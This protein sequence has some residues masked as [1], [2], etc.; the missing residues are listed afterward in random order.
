MTKRQTRKY[1]MLVRVQTFGV[2]HQKAFAEGSEVAK[3]FAAVTDAVSQITAFEMARLTAKRE[4]MKARHAA[5]LAL[6]ERIG[7][8]ARSARVMAKAI[9]GADAKFPLLTRRNDVAVLTSGRLF[10]QEATPLKD[11]FISCGLAPTFVEDLQRSIELLEQEIAGRSA[12]KTGAVVSHKGIRA[13]LKK[14]L[15]TVLSLD[16][17]VRNVLGHEANA[18]AAW[19]R[20]RHIEFA[21]RTAAA[22]APSDNGAPA[23][24]SPDEQPIAPVPAP[25]TQPT[26]SQPAEP[27]PVEEPTL[28]QRAA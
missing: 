13:A 14:G 23:P 15:D 7:S 10:L 12:G 24:A 17:L 19:K 18:M 26:A 21:G 8:I 6:A 9:P 27:S 20:G 16:V 2:T 1:E 4:S 25:S 3:A 5:N 28:P 11:T 22:A